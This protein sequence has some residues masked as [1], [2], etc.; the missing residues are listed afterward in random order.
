MRSDRLGE[1]KEKEGC[2][3]WFSPLAK[4]SACSGVKVTETIFASSWVFM[5]HQGWR[6][7]IHFAA[8]RSGNKWSELLRFSLRLRVLRLFT[9]FHRGGYAGFTGYLPI[10]I[11]SDFLRAVYELDEI[12]RR[13]APRLEESGTKNVEKSTKK[14]VSD[15][16][17]RGYFVLIRLFS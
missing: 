4:I 13:K 16:M 17:S 14:G 7:E 6:N 1:Q 10:R 15:E 11:P 5:E 3:G 8:C 2:P 12:R 9:F